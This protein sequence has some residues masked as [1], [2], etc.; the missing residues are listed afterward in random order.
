MR[1]VLLALAALPLAAVAALLALNLVAGGEPLGGIPGHAFVDPP[2]TAGVDLLAR[3][4]VTLRATEAFAAGPLRRWSHG[5]G[6]RDAWAAPVTAPVLRLDAFERRLRPFGDELDDV[7]GMTANSTALDGAFLYDVPEEVFVDEAR[8]LATSLPDD[9]VRAA[10]RRAW[11][12]EVYR[13]DG[14]RVAGHL[15]AR[16]PAL[17]RYA[18]R[19]REVIRS[20]GPVDVLAEA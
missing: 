12:A 13:L 3:D 7:R 2:D 5:R 4:S 14:E 18:R 16:R 10:L 20:R 9:A 1:R 11:S 8:A 6:Y 19:F 15:I 17:E